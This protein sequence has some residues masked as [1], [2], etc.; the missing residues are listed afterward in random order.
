MQRNA[1]KP[2][3]FDRTTFKA[4]LDGIYTFTGSV[5]STLTFN[6]DAGIGNS[7]IDQAGFFTVKN[8]GSANLTL[9]TA[10]VS[11][12]DTNAGGAVT[13]LTLTPG[14]GMVI[15]FDGTYLSVVAKAN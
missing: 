8:R 7:Y 10:G 6:A 3:T 14:Q 11:F 1:L 15:V 4:E 5:A 2:I 13:T 12:Y 9:A